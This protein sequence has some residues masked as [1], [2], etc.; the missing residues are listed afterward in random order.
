MKNIKDLLL[1]W[2]VIMPMVG[3]FYL[4]VKVDNAWAWW[5]EWYYTYRGIPFYKSHDKFSVHIMRTGDPV[6]KDKM[7]NESPLSGLRKAFLEAP[8]N[9]MDISL[10]ELVEKWDEPPTAIQILEVVDKAIYWGA[11]SGFVVS[12]L[13]MILDVAIKEENTTLDEL[14]EKAVWRNL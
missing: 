12:A 7:N 13:Q 10:R 11:A 8:D 14:V 3:V 1:T 4:M 9:Q 6:K 2:L 5:L